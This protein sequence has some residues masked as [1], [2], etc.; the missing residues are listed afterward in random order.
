MPSILTMLVEHAELSV[1]AL[2]SIRVLLFAGEVFPTKY[3]SR[4]MKLMPGVTFGN[5]YGPTETNVCT[6]YNVPEPPDEAAPP[7]SI[8]SAIGNVECF[9]VDEEHGRGGEGLGGGAA[10]AGPH[11]DAGLL[12]RSRPHQG[13]PD[14]RPA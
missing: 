3:L 11:R 6:Y 7:V 12:G 1:G 13:A 4:L 14:P 8:G 10:G 2:P 5:L 9:V